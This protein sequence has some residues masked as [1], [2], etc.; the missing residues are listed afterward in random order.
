MR[1]AAMTLAAALGLATSAAAE[2]ASV[3]VA[4]QYG[5][6]HVYVAPEEFDR[7]VASVLAT[8]GGAASKKAV[9]TITPTP[10]STLFQA[11][12][13]P[14]GP[15]SVFGFTT[16]IPVPFGAE[17]TGYLVTDMDAAVVAARAAGAS[18][19][20]APFADAIG[21]DAIIQWPGGVNMQL[22]WHTTPPH[23]APLRTIAENRVYLSPDSVGAFVQGFL[24]F[25]GGKIISDDTD[26]PG[27]EIGS[28]GKTY[29]RVRIE[30]AFGRM[31]VLVTD[32]HLSYPY[33][34]EIVGYEVA[35]LADT[36]AKAEASGVAVLVAPHDSDGR[37]A[38]MVQFPG[39]Y[40]AEIHA[41]SAT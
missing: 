2:L 18:V 21:R 17:R 13:T 22:Y 7:F 4:P 30:S 40:I 14:V 37:T 1:L 24:T 5:S 15:L 32:G 27:I 28:P 36:L 10:S 35:N 29:R 11:V 26:A 6:V 16:A 8:F 33:A 3:A 25:S 19:T 20:V 12:Q 39:G 34:L 9:V 23:A 41:P 38:A 31:A